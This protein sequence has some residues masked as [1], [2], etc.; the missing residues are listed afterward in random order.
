ML[1]V[2]PFPSWSRTA[3]TGLKAAVSSALRSADNERF[4]EH[5]RYI[6]IASQLLNDHVGPSSTLAPPTGGSPPISQ[7]PSLSVTTNGALVVAAL[8]CTF[9]LLVR[10]ARGGS[11]TEFY[12]DRL[13]ILLAVTVILALASYI[14]AA[15]QSL[16]YLR[17]QAI[18]AA[19]TF[20]ANAQALESSSSSVFTMIQEVE[21]ISRG[22][23]V[24]V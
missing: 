20:V 15:R 9:A 14:Y 13:S 10:W 11:R 22:Y 3:L 6:I 12:F 21:L 17:R 23:R 5:F 7:P 16:Y 2:P 1:S 24:Y 4:L 19:S 18:H 8:S